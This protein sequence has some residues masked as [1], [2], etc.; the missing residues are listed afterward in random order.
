MFSSGKSHAPETVLIVSINHKQ[1]CNLYDELPSAHLSPYSYKF[2]KVEESFRLSDS[3]IWQTERESLPDDYHSPPPGA[4]LLTYFTFLLQNGTNF[5][6][7][8]WFFLLCRTTADFSTTHFFTY[9]LNPDSFQIMAHV[10]TYA[11]NVLLGR[12][13]RTNR[14]WV[15]VLTRNS[16]TQFFLRHGLL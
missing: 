2:K 16:C 11:A 5:H 7:N 15:P 4:T 14:K 9:A 8:I 13:K 3:F 12:L 6:K 1:S 10:V